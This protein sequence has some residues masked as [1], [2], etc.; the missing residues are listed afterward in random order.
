VLVFSSAD[1]LRKTAIVSL[2]FGFGNRVPSFFSA[3]ILEIGAGDTSGGSFWGNVHS[4][5][6]ANL[7]PS[8]GL[9]TCVAL[10]FAVA[11]FAEEDF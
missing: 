5:H 4:G 8:Q 7:E 3:D 11:L 6:V 9:Y 2:T 10:Q 1:A